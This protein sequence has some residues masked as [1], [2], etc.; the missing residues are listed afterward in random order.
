MNRI[1]YRDISPGAREEAVFEAG[2]RQAFVHLTDLN[3]EEIAAPKT[4]TLECNRWELDGSLE[5]L[6]EAPGSA[7]WGYW[8]TAMSGEDCEL[9]EPPVMEISF[10]RQ[11][12]SVGLTLTFDP[13]AGDFC[14]EV[15]IQ[16]YRDGAL[17]DEAVFHP[18]RPEYACI[19]EVHL[20]DRIRLTFYTMSL[21]QR[22][23]R[24]QRVVFG[25]DRVFTDGELN[26]DGLN[27]LEEISPTG[28]ELS[29]N[30]LN[31][32]LRTSSDVPFLFQ[33]KQPLEVYHNG[34]PMGTFFI[35]KSKRKARDQ[36]QI[37]AIDP[38]G[39]LAESGDHLGGLYTGQSAWTVAREI[40]GTE[41]EL[42]MDAALMETPVT[43]W[44]PIA[45]RRDNLAQ[46]AI[47][48]GAIVDD[49]RGEG[50]R[51]RVPADT[52]KRA[53]GD[54]VIFDTLEVET[55]SLVTG[56]E[57]TAHS[58]ANSGGEAQTLYE[59]TPT[60]NETLVAFSQ[61]MHSLQITGGTITG[62]GANY[63]TF[64]GSG[65]VV[66][67]GVPYSHTTRI[68]AIRNRD[69]TATDKTNV[70]KVEGATLVGPHNAQA[71]ARRIYDYYSR[72]DTVNA[73]V[74]LDWE[75]VGDMVSI[76]TP[77]QGT[78]T[79]RISKLDISLGN[80]LVAK[81]VIR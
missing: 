77:F 40:V 9:V 69:L 5:I 75:Q 58:Y 65:P 12:T 45:S 6:P 2:Q 29:I 60:G 72:R 54:G 15:R 30:T 47:A 36:Y 41:W 78:Y 39:V 73:D 44:L 42:E 38:V 43:G 13:D 3:R 8:S 48:L 37:D 26:D 22:Y 80:E 66:L 34:R 71:V 19:R 81:V 51:L 33:K 4:A 1:E 79:G 10:A 28:A 63:A 23:L 68:I 76:A 32:S 21:P 20:Y 57:V 16:W 17:Q 31:F 11:H 18:D 7:Q 25:I 27:I 14:R 49:S 62:S 74:L 59:D 67:T 70:K 56:V 53:L 52:I 55:D 24:V 46:L 61:P 50:I 35:D 64:T